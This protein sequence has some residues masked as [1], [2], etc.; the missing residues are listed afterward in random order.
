MAGALK[1]FFGALQ[2]SQYMAGVALQFGEEC[3][4]AQEPV[5]PSITMVPRGGPIG[6]SG[7]ALNTDPNVEMLWGI[8]ES[9][10]FY[11][12]AAASSPTAQPIDHADAVESLR[13]L[14][15]S[16]MRDQQ[17]QYTDAASV[18]Y[19]LAWKA[20]NERWA[21]DN[22]ALLR[23]GRCLIVTCEPEITVPMA[24]IPG[25]PETTITSTQQTPN[26]IDAP[27]G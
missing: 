9:V 22:D 15:L 10:D 5:L 27:S 21:T 14:F 20:V 8:T 4:R 3:I 12:W 6:A 13:Q 25:G 26:V 2:A 1:T 11:L 16:A 23:F 18:S 7:Y 17:A 19:G 24:S